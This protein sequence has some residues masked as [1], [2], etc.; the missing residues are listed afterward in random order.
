MIQHRAREFSRARQGFT[1]IE[2]LVVIAII[3]IIAGF[4]VPTLLRGRG[5]AYKVQCTNNLKQLYG[6]ALG[7]SQKKG[8]NAYP[9][10]DGKEPAAHES[11]NKMVDY[12]G[13]GL[14]P[15]LFICPEGE[16][17][18]AEVDAGKFTLSAETLSYS[19]VKKRM[20][21]TTPNKALSSD[22]YIQGF[23]DGTDTHQGHQKGMVV[24][25]TDGSVS[26]VEESDP[27][28]ST[29]D[30]IPEGLTR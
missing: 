20:K 24:L 22:K 19:W 6:L 11:L 25:M 1:L 23:E 3:S 14:S 18:A 13:E 10:G 7:Y 30:K 4:L 28:L 16:A 26:F 8:N 12:E 27:M 21:S 5:E 2:L 9:I 17:S 29:E 15:K